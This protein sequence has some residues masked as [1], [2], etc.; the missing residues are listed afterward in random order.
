MMEQTQDEELKEYFKSKLD[1][2]RFILNCVERRQKTMEA[3]AGAILRKQEDYLS[4]SG[5]LRPMTMVEVADDISMHQSTVGR[6]IKG[7]YIQSPSGTFLIR[8]LFSAKAASSDSGEGITAK[9]IKEI[10]VDII[11]G[12]DKKRPYSDARIVE[13][14]RKRGVEISRRA[15]AKYRKEL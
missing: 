14:L 9:V 1:R 7:K 5:R 11:D 10:I 8:N 12:E 6:A 13:Q 2:C 3:I 4:G 15:V